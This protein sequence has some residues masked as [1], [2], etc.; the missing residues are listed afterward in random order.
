MDAAG[1]VSLKSIDDFDFESATAAAVDALKA[2]AK[3]HDA[4]LWIGA[5]TE[6]RGVDNA[7]TGAQSAPTPLRQHFDALDVIVML[8]PDSDAVHL[9]LLKDHDNPDVS[10]LNLHLDPTSMRVISDDLPPPPTHNRRAAE[11]HLYSG[12]ARGAESCFGECAARWGAAETH[13]SYAGH[14]FL[15]RTEGVRVLTEEELRRGDFSLKYASHRLDRPLSQIPNIKR[16]LQTAWY[17]INAANEVFVVG[18]LQENGTVRG[19]TGWGAELARLWHKPITVFDQHCGKWMR[20]D[21]TQ[22]REV[23]APVISRRAFAGIGTTSL[24]EEGRA[25]IVALFERSFGPA[26]Q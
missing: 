13:F 24:T 25:A 5:T 16:I 17:Q 23:K 14:P 10:A 15:E 19:G 21:S 3:K 7:A 11:F 20:W 1:D 4:E 8:R 22:W 6:E 18:A 12:G 9:Q 26:P 2:L